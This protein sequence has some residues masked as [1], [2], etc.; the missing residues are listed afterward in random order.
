MIFERHCSCHVEQSRL[1]SRNFTRTLE[2]LLIFPPNGSHHKRLT[3]HEIGRSMMVAAVIFGCKLDAMQVRLRP[4]RCYS[5]GGSGIA[6]TPTRA[7]YS[8]ACK[9][10]LPARSM[11]FNKLSIDE[12]S[13]S[14][15]VRNHCRKLIVM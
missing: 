7:R 3:M 11:I 1:P 6:L 14:C 9:R 13:S 12:T 8:S 5:F 10:S 15:S 4:S 2:T